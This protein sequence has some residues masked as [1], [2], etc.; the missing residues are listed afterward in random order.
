MVLELGRRRRKA[1]A[2]TEQDVPQVSLREVQ[3]EQDAPQV[4][5]RE[6][7]A[8]MKAQQR[9]RNREWE[10]REWAKARERSAA[11]AARA[12]ADRAAGVESLAEKSARLLAA[13]AQAEA[14]AAGAAGADAPAP[15][16]PPPPPPGSAPT[17]ARLP[18]ASEASV[19]A[20]L[21]RWPSPAVQPVAGGGVRL[22]LVCR[23]WPLYHDHYD[24]ID[25][26][27]VKYGFADAGEVLRHLVFV[28]NSEPPPVKKL[29][30]LSIRC[31]HCHAGQRAGS[32]PKKEKAAPLFE[33]QLQWLAAVKERSKHPA[34]EK[35]VRIIC[36]YYRKATSEKEGAEAELMGRN[37]ASHMDF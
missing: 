35:T 12:A 14:A 18:G 22:N 15:A 1:A 10:A 23:E 32:I 30:F 33:F 3:A 11:V 20:E 16:A 24:W 31:L 28:A 17:V 13:R 2:C 19:A 7:Q 21:R 27:A 4:S 34:I 5:L 25:E 6:V 8:E 37:R 9:L 36:D 29:I 26:V